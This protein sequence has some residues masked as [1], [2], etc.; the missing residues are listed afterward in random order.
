VRYVGL[1][2]RAVAFALDGAI[3]N[4]IAFVVGVGAGLI[5][6]LLH[7]TTALRDV[8]IVLGAGAYVLFT[9]GY[10]I[11]FWCTTGQ[12]PGARVM[13]FR[14]V[15]AKGERIKPRRALLRWI[16]LLL[17]ALPLL[18]GYLIIPFDRRRRGLQDFLARTLVVDAPQLSIAELRRQQKREARALAVPAPAGRGV[19]PSASARAGRSPHS[20]DDREDARPQA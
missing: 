10:F 19:Q 3:I 11:A 13:Q 17:A 2:T 8:L 5:L 6:S 1:T 15:A 20:G 16:G 7:V 14:V 18:A 4:V 12:T 9:G